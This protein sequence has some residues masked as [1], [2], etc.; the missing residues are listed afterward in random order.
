MQMMMAFFETEAEFS[1]R[2]DPERSPAYWGAWMAY[3]DA[4]R[5]AGV[6]L[7]GNPLHPPATASTLR[8]RGGTRQVQDGPFADSKEQLAGYVILEVPDLDV[9]LAWAERAP[10]A[11]TGAVEVR[12]VLLCPGS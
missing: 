8:R 12:P 5:A 1:A 7:G 11:V 2:T 9:A 4:L 3:M 10:C 6:I